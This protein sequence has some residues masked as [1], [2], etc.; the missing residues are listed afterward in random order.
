MILPMTERHMGLRQILCI[1]NL[2]LLAV[3]AAFAGMPNQTP[4]DSGVGYLTGVVLD[5]NNSAV[6]GATVTVERG[7]AKYLITTGQDGSFNIQLPVGIYRIRAENPG[8]CLSRRAAFRLRPSITT[9]INLR[10]IVCPLVHSLILEGRKAKGET[11]R[12]QSPFKEEEFSVTSSGEPL[13][14]LVQYGARIVRGHDIQYKGFR[15]TDGRWFGAIVTH[16]IFTI[17]AD[18]VRFNAKSLLIEA[19]GNVIFENGTERAKTQRV[20][21]DL[22]SP[23]PRVKIGL[24]K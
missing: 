8:F 18:K 22:K 7:E 16:D 10:L 3:S 13:T 5:T 15:L 4:T 21:V 11:S 12:Y 23:E 24:K 17:Y 14:L 9:T 20:D 2:L 6:A 1:A 19:E